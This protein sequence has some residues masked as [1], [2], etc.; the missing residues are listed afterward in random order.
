MVYQLLAVG[1]GFLAALAVML[2]DPVSAGVVFLSLQC[3]SVVFSVPAYL[4]SGPRGD[5]W[6]KRLI[7]QLACLSRPGGLVAAGAAAALLAS[8][9]TPVPPGR[10]LLA[11]LLA[12]AFGTFLAG[13]C[14]AVRALLGSRLAQALA[15]VV[16]L[17]MVSTPYYVDPF[18][19]ATS[20]ALRMRVVQVAVNI[21]PLLVGAA[22]ILNFDW[23]R[24][25]DLYQ[26]CLIGGWQ[27][28]FYY[29]STLKAGITLSVIG[30]ILIAVS[31]ARRADSC[32][33]SE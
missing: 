33:K 15:L 18:I 28:P 9:V 8:F 20:G 1:Y 7:E 23:L 26:T 19:R 14:T 4:S 11:S 6:S 13:V 27:F 29:P 22:G 24:H 25:P 32:E 3:L 17:L 21:N 16:G 5:A 2:L 12:L 30:I 31:A 10:I